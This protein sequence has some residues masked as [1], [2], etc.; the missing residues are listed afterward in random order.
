MMGFQDSIGWE[1][2]KNVKSDIKSGDKRSMVLR[3]Q[4]VGCPF[5]IRHDP[6]MIYDMHI[7]N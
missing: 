6:S 7:P 5:D 3:I 4:A 2:V 1:G